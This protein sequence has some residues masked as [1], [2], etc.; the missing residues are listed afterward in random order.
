M[1]EI[2]D[3]CDLMVSDFRLVSMKIDALV[4]RR[5]EILD[6]MSHLD[7]SHLDAVSRRAIDEARG[8]TS[9]V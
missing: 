4:K 3:I 2:D 9:T 8:G 7:R 1:S 5:E 6:E